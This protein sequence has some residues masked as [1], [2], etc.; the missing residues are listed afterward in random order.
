ML[1]QHLSEQEAK[2]IILQEIDKDLHKIEAPLSLL[3]SSM[4]TWG[5][6][7]RRMSWFVCAWYQTRDFQDLTKQM[8]AALRE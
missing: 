5:D 3:P 6:S 7:I 1:S 8:L 2:A 4:K